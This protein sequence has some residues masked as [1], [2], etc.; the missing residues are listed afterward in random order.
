MGNVFWQ[1]K[2]DQHNI[3]QVVI[4]LCLIS[5][6]SINKQF[7]CNILLSGMAKVSNF[8]NSVCTAGRCRHAAC[9]ET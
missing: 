1:Q 4:M 9:R 5:V 7:L 6:Y 3:R 8:M 2:G